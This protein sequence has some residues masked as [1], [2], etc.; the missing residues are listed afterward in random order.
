MTEYKAEV[1]P[2]PAYTASMT[3]PFGGGAVKSVN[4]KTGDVVLTAGDVGASSV[5]HRRDA[6]SLVGLNATLVGLGSVDN[7]RD[8]QKPVSVAQAAAIAGRAPLTHRHA[9]SDMDGRATPAQLGTGTASASTVLHGDG[10]FRA[11]AGSGLDLA[12]GT[13]SPEGAVV[14]TVGQRY[15]DTAATAGASSWIKR[16]GT[17]NTG[18][19]VLS[20]DTEWRII[21]PTA[22]ATHL[23]TNP[24]FVTSGRMMVRRINDVVRFGLDDLVFGGIASGTVEIRFDIPEGFRIGSV[25]PGMIFAQA[26]GAVAGGAGIRV[27]AYGSYWTLRTVSATTRLREFKNFPASPSAYPAA[28]LPGAIGPT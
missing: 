20:A 8:A 13:G 9:F 10:V 1:Q 23:A 26:G 25:Y 12:P 27:D 28:P 21:T 7:T 4:T 6:A 18:W 15:T 24:G 3:Q 22:F 16:T 11:P 5:G 19:R 14:G 2:Q 17:G